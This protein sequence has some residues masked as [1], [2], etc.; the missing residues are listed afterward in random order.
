MQNNF[1]IIQNFEILS[2][3]FELFEK[4]QFNFAFLADNYFIS[5]SN[6][7]FCHL[8][9]SRA[10]SRGPEG[11][12]PDQ[13]CGTHSLSCDHCGVSRGWCEVCRLEQITN[14]AEGCTEEREHVRPA[15]PGSSTANKPSQPF[16]ATGLLPPCASPLLLK[17]S[18]IR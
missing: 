1:K 12:S 16:P 5:N 3:V 10:A 17:E 14:T 7:R 6:T 4:F 2:N 15:H 13:Q 18:S 8:C 11:T 9:K